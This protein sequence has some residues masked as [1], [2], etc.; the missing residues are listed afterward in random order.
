MPLPPY[1]ME[2][3]IR[4]P[5][6]TPP[7]DGIYGTPPVL[8]A[9]SCTPFGNFGPP[10]ISLE[11]ESLSQNR[12]EA[13]TT[14]AMIKPVSTT[15]VYKKDASNTSDLARNAA[16]TPT[17][18]TMAKGP[19]T[20]AA[21]TC[22]TTS[23]GSGGVAFNTSTKENMAL[24]PINH[25][26]LLSPKVVV[27][28]YPKLLVCSKLPTL[29]VKLAKEAYFGP[30]VMNYCT[31]HGVG[32]HHALPPAEVKKMK[33]FLFKISFPDVVTSRVEFEDTWTRCIESVGQKCK[34]LRNLRLAN[35]ELK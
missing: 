21:S 29:A 9:V 12:C 14:P 3:G 7:V 23:T 22:P 27:E 24:P 16:I 6:V 2:H 11:L 1:Y 35:L 4:S 17:I 28:K 10:N 32:S 19:V 15:P 25:A 20:T 5:C 30:E 34:K 8:P 26:A 13:N 18:K 33:E 31:F